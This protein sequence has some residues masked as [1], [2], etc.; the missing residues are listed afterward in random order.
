MTRAVYV[1]AGMT[2]GSCASSVSAEVGGLAGVAKVRVDLGS[3]SVEVTSKDPLD[4]AAVQEAVKAA[5]Y[6][7]T[8]P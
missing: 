8:S 3:G 2:C 6:E 5:G 4:D 7:V 1:V